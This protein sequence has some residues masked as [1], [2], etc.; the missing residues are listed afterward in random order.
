MGTPHPISQNGNT[1]PP[2]SLIIMPVPFVDEWVRGKLVNGQSA[3]RLTDFLD[4]IDQRIGY[5]SIESMNHQ[6]PHFQSQFS[7]F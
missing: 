1:T 5:V 6:L 4:L 3:S 7:Q 2:S